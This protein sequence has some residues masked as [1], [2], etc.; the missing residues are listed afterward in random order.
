MA[1]TINT[2]PF[3]RQPVLTKIYTLT[4]PRD[5]LIKYVGYTTK[6]L[7]KRLTGHLNP[8]T[9]KN[10][11]KKNSWIKSLKKQR[12]IPIIELID[13]VKDYNF[14]ECHYI[15]LY[16]SWGFPL[17]NGTPGGDGRHGPLSLE[18]RKKISKTL[19]G[20]MPKNIQ[21]F[22]NSGIKTRRYGNPKHNHDEIIKLLREGLTVKEIKEKI[23]CCG[24]T[25]L[26]INKKHK[27]RDLKEESKIL[28]S[29]ANSGKK[30]SEESK[31]KMSESRKKY[32]K[33]CHQSL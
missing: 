31:R 12:L 27:I 15:S 8:A 29:I 5:G 26:S 9:L 4:D 7:E 17:T 6:T 3:A 21:M 20:R 30:R 10:K 13:E 25:I 14:W 2:Q 24:I 28:I 32:L 22:I 18:T 1:I 19:K 16:K 33:R 23:G 11:S